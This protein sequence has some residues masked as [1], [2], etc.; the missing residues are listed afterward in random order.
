MREW[1]SQNEALRARAERAGRNTIDGKERFMP[2]MAFDL[3]DGPA[4]SI[5]LALLHMKALE[6]SGRV[7]GTAARVSNA[8]SKAL[9]EVWYISASLMM[10][11]VKELSFKDAL[12]FV[13]EG[14][15]RRTQMAVHHDLSDELPTCPPEYIKIFAARFV[16]VCLDGLSPHAGTTHPHVCVHRDGAAVVLEIKG[17]C[18][19]AATE[20][21]TA[22]SI[23]LGLAGIWD[24]IESIGGTITVVNGPAGDVYLAARLPFSPVA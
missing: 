2:R 18:H 19:D 24:Q 5:S 13:F 7:E 12:V 11:E 8:L 1:V 15:G 10:P 16:Q 20:N 23:Q 14:H 17:W 3:R 21:T 4:Q 6:Q 9:R 22:Q